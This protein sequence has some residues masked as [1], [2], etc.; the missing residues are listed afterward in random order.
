MAG[1]GVAGPPHGCIRFADL[2]D[3]PLQ[4]IGVSQASALMDL[5]ALVS[6]ERLRELRLLQ[7]PLTDADRAQLGARR[8]G[9]RE[10]SS[11]TAPDPLPVL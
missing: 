3:A 4:K 8:P 5:E 6:L 10:S 2:R 11:P 7:G 9:R 1:A